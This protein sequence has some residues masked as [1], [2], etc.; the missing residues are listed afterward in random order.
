MLAMSKNVM[1]AAAAA[2]VSVVAIAVLALRAGH[3]V[4]PLP[5]GTTAA[6][7]IAKPEPS[8][9]EATQSQ[10]AL[11]SFDIVRVE[12]TGETV[13]AGRAQPGSLV[14]LLGSGK[15]LGS[16]KADANGHFVILP[17]SL[18][19]GSHDLSLVQKDGEGEKASSQTVAVG[20]PE[21]G[22]GEIVVA[23]A[24]PGKPTKVLSEAGPAAV[25]DKPETF[26]PGVSIRT[27]EAEQDGGF[28]AS[29]RAAPGARLRIY[30]N[31]TLLADVTADT[32]GQWSLR[33][34]KG[35]TTGKYAVRADQIDPAR[36]SVLARAE[37]P[38]AYS[39]VDVTAA[40]ATSTIAAP[41]GSVLTSRK[42]NAG[43]VVS[44]ASTQSAAAVAPVAPASV[45]VDKV[46]TASV[47]R[48]DS[49][50]RISRKMLGQGVRYTQIYDANTSQIRDPR[51]I[52]PGQILVMP[53]GQPSQ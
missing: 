2:A 35:M 31:E 51:R 24:E 41:A 8:Q 29:G 11:P 37:A 1:L 30:L 7:P 44:D 32:S 49:L 28:Y 43:A 48:G 21:K 20:V 10:A 42:E 6:S 15:P 19:P 4:L 16:A 52:Y 17:E 40:A 45:T 50:W 5:A 25:G 3:D 27:V 39:P 47:V 14:T 26:T 18:P 12:P 33:I 9:P 38:F 13:V 22:V 53:A 36:G 46:A 23:L 34:A